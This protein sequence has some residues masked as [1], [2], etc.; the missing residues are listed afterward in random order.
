MLKTGFKPRKLVSKHINEGVE[1]TKELIKSKMET[2]ITE[3]EVDI[4]EIKTKENNQ[5]FIKY[6]EWYL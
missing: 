2:V 1:L 3:R 6:F 4:D 5:D